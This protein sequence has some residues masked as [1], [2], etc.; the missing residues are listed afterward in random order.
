MKFIFKFFFIILLFISSLRV[1]AQDPHFSQFYANPM[2]LN[3]AYTGINFCPTWVVNY[4]NQWPALPGDYVTYNSSFDFGL[5]EIHGGLGLIALHDNAGSGV[6]TTNKISLLYSYHS[7]LSSTTGLYAG[8]QFTYFQRKLNTNHFFGDQI[9]ELYGFIYPTFDPLSAEEYFNVNYTD[10]SAGILLTQDRYWLGF[11]AHHLTEPNYA[12]L[13]SYNE[14]KLP[15]KITV[16]GGSKIVVEDLGWFNN[17]FLSRFTTLTPHFVFQ[18]QAESEQINIGGLL[19]GDHLGVGLGYRRG[20][21]NSDA[22]IILL[23]YE[24]TQNSSTAFFQGLKIGYSYDLTISK[25]GLSSGGAHE[26]SLRMQLPCIYI[27]PSQNTIPC[28][29][30]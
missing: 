28:P 8:F 14:G 29:K 20:F 10:L 12:F 25:L 30:F 21:N 16:H 2:Y 6:M 26:I 23:G 19:S 4:R 13:D 17:T 15:M 27:S 3:P 9:D 18:K 1:T 22:L 5:N 11:A 24:T 7:R